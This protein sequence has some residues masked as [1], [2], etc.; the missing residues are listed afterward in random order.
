MLSLGLPTNATA[1][2]ML[3]ALISAGIVPGPQLMTREPDLVWALIASLFIGNTILLILNLP[4]APLWAKLLR[5]PRPYLYAGILFFA[6][7][8]AYAVNGTAFD[9]ILLAALGVLGFALRRFALPVLPLVVGVILAS[10]LEAQGRR[11]LQLS[12]GDPRGMFGGINIATG[13]FQ[14]SWLVVFIYAL[15]IVALAWPLV[16]WL[17]R[18]FFPKQAVA[19]EEFTEELHTDIETD[20][21]GHPLATSDQ[22]DDPERPWNQPKEKQDVDG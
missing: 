8:G 10:R 15:I 13:E 1:S 5:V 4:L 20:D 19:V 6:S 14:V 18:K 12:S 17:I 7:M 9:L 3:A 21:H 2:I 22:P 11:A 16:L